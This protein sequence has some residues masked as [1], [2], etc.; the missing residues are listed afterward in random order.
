MVTTVTPF[1]SDFF[2]PSNRCQKALSDFL[3]EKRSAMPRFYFIGDEDLLEIL[4]QVSVNKSNTW[5]IPRCP[6][7]ILLCS[8]NIVIPAQNALKPRG[9]DDPLFE[10]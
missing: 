9:R 8:K 5:K 4:G 7:R 1:V 3:E 2:P 6:C 10:S